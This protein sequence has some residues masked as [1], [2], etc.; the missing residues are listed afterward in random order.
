M[1]LR[2]HGSSG[3]ASLPYVMHC[4]GLRDAL[5]EGQVERK[6]DSKTEEPSLSF[7]G[8]N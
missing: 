7:R 6:L 2:L 3:Y 4:G 1:T 5:E 8:Y